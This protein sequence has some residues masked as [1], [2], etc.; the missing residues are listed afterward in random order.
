[1]IPHRKSV[2]REC[3]ESMEHEV[4]PTY[5]DDFTALLHVEGLSAIPQPVCCKCAVG[6]GDLPRSNHDRRRDTPV[7]RYKASRCHGWNCSL[8]RPFLTR[9]PST[10][11][12]DVS[13]YVAA[14]SSLALKQFGYAWQLDATRGLVTEC[15]ICST[16]QEPS[17]CSV[18]YFVP[19]AVEYVTNAQTVQ[20]HVYQHSRRFRRSP[21]A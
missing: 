10:E 3:T 7:E 2:A 4:I 5:T 12:H 21:V 16:W 17:S 6:S 18:Y 19:R 1:M 8:V 15:F 11:W 20:Y 14:L 9:E 13:L